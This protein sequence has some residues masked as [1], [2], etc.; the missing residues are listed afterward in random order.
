MISFF[1]WFHSYFSWITSHMQVSK[2]FFPTHEKGEAVCLLGGD[3]CTKKKVCEG[4]DYKSKQL[5]TILSSLI[6]N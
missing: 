6:T 3:N 1:Y 2:D 5:Y 4:K